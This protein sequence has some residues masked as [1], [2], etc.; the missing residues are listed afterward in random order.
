MHEVSLPICEDS[1][2]VITKGSVGFVNI[3]PQAH[4]LVSKCKL[5]EPLF[6]IDLVPEYECHKSTVNSDVPGKYKR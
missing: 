1:I 4:V 2:T 6:H 3:Y 5:N